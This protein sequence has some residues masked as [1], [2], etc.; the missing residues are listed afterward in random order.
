MNGILYKSNSEKYFQIFVVK[1]SYQYCR[2]GHFWVIQVAKKCRPER[3]EL[4]FSSF[5]EKC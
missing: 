5:N 3:L 4:K 2:I 1:L